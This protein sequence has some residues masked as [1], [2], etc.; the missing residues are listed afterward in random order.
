MDQSHVCF[1]GVWSSKAPVAGVVQQ[2]DQLHTKI[3]KFARIEWNFDMARPCSDEGYPGI[4][5]EYFRIC[6][7]GL[8]Y[9]FIIHIVLPFYSKRMEA[10]GI[11][12]I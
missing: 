7:Q 6:R 4:A 1:C 8:S 10:L 9:A 2:G 3:L 5:T 11:I 12:E